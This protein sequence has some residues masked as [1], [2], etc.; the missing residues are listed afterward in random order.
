MP[1]IKYENLNKLTP[2]EVEVLELMAQGL[3]NK[4]ISEIL[5]IGYSTVS[6]HVLS[7]YDKLN[8]HYKNS[9]AIRVRAVLWYQVHR[10]E[11]KN[12]E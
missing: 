1:K 8:I 11:L 6:T 7:I 10:V 3:S 12:E 2:R 5:F 9:N 4:E